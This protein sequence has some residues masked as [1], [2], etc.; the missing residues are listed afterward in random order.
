MTE[1]RFGAFQREAHVQQLSISANNLA[2]VQ[3]SHGGQASGFRSELEL[4]SLDF[5]RLVFPYISTRAMDQI[6]SVVPLALYL[7]LFQIIVF[8]QSIL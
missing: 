6:R 1:I 7:M 5:R 4:T 2:E 8:R 3:G